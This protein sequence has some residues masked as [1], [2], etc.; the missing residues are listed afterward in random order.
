MNFNIE[1]ITEDGVQVRTKVEMGS[2]LTDRMDEDQLA[3]AVIFFWK[4]LT[5]LNLYKDSKVADQ[6]AGAMLGPGKVAIEEAANKTRNILVSKNSPASE[7][8]PPF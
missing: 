6:V 4:A 8:G 7:E 5:M 2:T 1:G 3:A